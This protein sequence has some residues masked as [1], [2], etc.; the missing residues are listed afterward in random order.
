MRLVSWATKAFV[1]FII[2][3][4]LSACTSTE[5][6][7]HKNTLEETSMKQS[8]VGVTAA[9]QL[10]AEAVLSGEGK[11]VY[12][13]LS[14]QCRE[15][16][17]ASEISSQLKTARSY[18]TS[19]V[20][21]ELE[22]ISIK[23]VETQNVKQG[24]RGQARFTIDIKGKSRDA[25]YAA[26]EKSFYATSTTG[27]EQTNEKSTYVYPFDQPTQWFEFVY[28]DETWKLKDCEEFLA[29]SSLVSTPS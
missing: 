21:A 12:R 23:S 27:P 22:D 14:S 18:L 11:V 6:S 8:S 25:V 4:T 2:F 17:T 7:S 3:A 9:A 24:D 10:I 20:G 29:T 15:K 16:V 5:T 13:H 1:A 19:F 26:L 28:E